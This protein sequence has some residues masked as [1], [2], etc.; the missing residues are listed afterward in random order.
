MIR[1]SSVLADRRSMHGPAPNPAPSEARAEPL[2]MLLCGGLAMLAAAFAGVASAADDHPV[3]AAVADFDNFDTAGES[4]DR[5]AAHAARVEAFAGLLRDGLAAEGRFAI[6]EL[7]CP[8]TPCSPVSVPPARFLQAGRDSGARLLVY[9][10]IHKMSTLVQFGQ[11]QAVD[12]QTNA[13]VL[14]QTITFR[15]DSDEAFR[16]AAT[17]VADYLKDVK[18][19]P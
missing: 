12:L 15:G 9:G 14:N 6:V 4:G 8:A 5:T 16:R 13:L 17:F 18:L 2:R 3:P 11:V 1:T 10:G 7:A 19:D